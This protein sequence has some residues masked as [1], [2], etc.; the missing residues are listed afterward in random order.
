MDQGR[1]NALLSQERARLERLLAAGSGA[2]DEPDLGDEVDNADRR[3]AEE[4]GEAVDQFLRDQWAA[5]GRAEARLASGSYGRSVL[6]GRP[7][8]DER[9]EADPLAELTV[10]E[11]AAQERG[12]FEEVEDA[13]GLVSARQPYEVLDDPD[14]T[15]EEQLADE[16]DED[17]PAPGQEPGI[18]IER[19]DRRR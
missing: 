13:P 17:E 7:I 4:T 12:T 10:E 16:E 18:H 2:P 6:S 11:A 5:L 14:I 19:D 8:P 15:P 3:D 1:A 9:L